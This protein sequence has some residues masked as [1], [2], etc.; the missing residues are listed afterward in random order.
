MCTSSTA[1]VG[2]DKDSEKR[3]RAAIEAYAKANDIAIVAWHYDKAVRGSDPVTARHGVLTLAIWTG[4]DGARRYP[5]L[6]FFPART[7]RRSG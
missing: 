4:K 6:P 3:Q 2:A 1:N 5:P 7:G